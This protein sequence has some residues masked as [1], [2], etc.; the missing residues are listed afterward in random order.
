[1]YIV[2]L[3]LLGN[4]AYGRTL[5]N[6]ESHKDVSF[7][8]SDNPSFFNLVNNKRFYNLEELD[9]IVE[10]ETKKSNIKLDIPIQVGFFVLEYA[11]LLLLQ[12][13]YDF[14]AV[15][16]PFDSF[17]L[18]ESDTDSMYFSLSCFCF[19]CEDSIKPRA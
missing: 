13:Y 10:I 17:A 12:F 9:D 18:I 2:L 8:S 15:F 11:K 1:M 16:L 19:C 3:I 14:L 6:R 4:S 5:V 7:H